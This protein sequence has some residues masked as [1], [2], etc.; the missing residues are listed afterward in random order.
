MEVF[1]SRFD[2]LQYTLQKQQICNITKTV[3]LYRCHAPS[4]SH[5]WFHLD[6]AHASDFLITYCRKPKQVIRP[7]RIKRLFLISSN[8][9]LVKFI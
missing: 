2:K 7:I 5:D 3:R 8:P 4:S 6:F 1:S 9:Q